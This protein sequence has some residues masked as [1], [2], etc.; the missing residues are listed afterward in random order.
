MTVLNFTDRLVIEV[1]CA[2]GINFAMGE[3]YQR[4]RMEDHRSFYCPSGHAQSYRGKSE[5]EKLRERNERLAQ[6]LASREED[7]RAERVRHSSTKGQ[8]TK[9]KKR[10]AAGVC[11][12]CNRTFQNVSRHVAGQHPEF[13]AENL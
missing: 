11:P 4:R 3:T 12:C 10:A 9:S 7:L 6:Q 8:L 5:A 1:C 2:C 13:V